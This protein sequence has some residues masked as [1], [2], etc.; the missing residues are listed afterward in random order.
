MAISHTLSTAGKEAVDPAV[1]K[2]IKYR[3]IVHEKHPHIVS[4]PLQVC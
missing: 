3:A 1:R 2:G 4:L